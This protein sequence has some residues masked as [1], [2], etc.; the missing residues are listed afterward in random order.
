MASDHDRQ[1]AVALLASLAAPHDQP[2]PDGEDHCWRRCRN[3]L[4]QEE[5]GTKEGRRLLG[6][7]KAMLD[8][9]E[10]MH[11]ELAPAGVPPEAEEVK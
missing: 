7:V 5:A 4:A 1:K 9:R 2:N 6:I 10:Q 11:S 3:C 8:E